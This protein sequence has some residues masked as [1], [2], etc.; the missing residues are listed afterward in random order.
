M[1]L[2]AGLQAR[3]DSEQLERW[4]SA[5]AAGGNSWRGPSGAHGGGQGTEGRERQW[6]GRGPH[7]AHPQPH[8]GHVEIPN[9]QSSKVAEG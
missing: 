1:M 4:N 2:S 8:A 6:G 9:E 3:K 7:P 5:Q